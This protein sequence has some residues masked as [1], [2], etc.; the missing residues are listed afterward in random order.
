MRNVVKVA[1]ADTEA[2]PTPRGVGE[3]KGT[4]T[5]KAYLPKR[6]SARNEKEVIEYDQVRPAYHDDVA[7]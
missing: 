3:V 4:P 6:S 1:Y 2:G 5:I 7:R